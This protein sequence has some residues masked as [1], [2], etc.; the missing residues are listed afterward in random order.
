MYDFAVGGNVVNATQINPDGESSFPIHDFR[1]QLREFETLS[2][3]GKVPWNANNSVFINMFGIDDVAV[4]VFEDRNWT[5]AKANLQP[6]NGDYFDLLDRM[7]HLGAHKII[8][9]LVPRKSIVELVTHSANHRPIAIARAPIFDYGRADSSSAA[10]IR[11]G[12][13]WWNNHI[14][15]QN[16]DFLAH[17]SEAHSKIF[18]PTPVFDRILDN[19]EAYGAPNSTCASYPQ[20]EPCLWHDFIHPGKVIQHEFGE[21][22]VEVVKSMEFI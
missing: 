11:N 10:E 18:D 14:H 4:Q 3:G 7:Y 2:S 19:P 21:S 8:T 17:H 1:G 13:E 20:G 5:T 16:G 6:D 12:T 9:V 22:M 15:N